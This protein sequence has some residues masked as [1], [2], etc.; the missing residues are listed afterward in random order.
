MMKKTIGLLAHVDAGKTTLAEQLLYHTKTLRKPGRVD[1]RNTFLDA[2]AIEKDRGITIFS[3]QAVTTYNDS[4]YY[5]VDTPGHVDFSPEMERAI[6]VMDYAIVIISGVEGVEGHTETV[7]RLLRKHHI[8]TFFFINKTDREIAD[9][10]AVMKQISENLT[11]NACDISNTFKLNEM[12][13]E[14]M[15]FMAERDEKLLESYLSGD[16][17]HTFWLAAMK[18]LI[19][20]NRIFPCCSGSALQDTGILEFLEKLDMLTATNYSKSGDFSGSVYKIR[21]DDNGTKITFIKALKGQLTVKD[22]ISF[23]Q[24]GEILTE[25]INEIRLYNG[26]QFQTTDTISAGDLFAVLGLSKAST[27][28]GLGSLQEKPDYEM[29]PTLQSKV[30]FDPEMDPMAVLKAFK[31]LDAEDPALN[32]SWEAKTGDIHIK[33]MGIVQLE[34][35]ERLVKERFGFS[36]TFDKPQILYKETIKNTVRGYGHFEPLKHYAEVHLKLEPGEPNSKITFENA[37]H[38]DKLSVGYQNLI[39]QHL[40]EK[41]HHG[42]LTGSPLTDIKIT[43]LM[44]RSHNKHTSGGDFKEAVYRALRQGLEKATNRLLEPYYT[45]RIQVEFHHVGRVLSDIQ[46]ASGT[47]VPPVTEGN[48][49]IISGNAPVATFM[50]YPTQLASFTQGKGFIHLVFSGY[51]PCHNEKEIIEKLNYNKDADPEYTSSSIF[52]SKGKGYTVPWDQAEKQMH[53]L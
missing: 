31:I 29:I 2:H 22:T 11:P 35:L 36:V 42:I 50:D 45:F 14:L 26:N 7:W 24:G 13:K 17:N 15:E 32:V 47:F 23:T 38:P 30:V 16:K 49:A 44:G 4:I 19:Q 43:L 51:A 9:V 6:M 21:H 41:E 10:N 5:L 27:G 8:P 52:C 20:Q 3:D 39:R 34:V 1:H 28:T 18:R 25:K 37:C 48:K 46:K 40:L 12:K 33:V 53:C